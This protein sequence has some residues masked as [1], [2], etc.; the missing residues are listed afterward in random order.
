MKTPRPIFPTALSGGPPLT[1][2]TIKD[3][4]EAFEWLRKQAILDVKQ[5]QDALVE[6]DALYRE[7]VRMK[8][9]LRWIEQCETLKDARQ[10]A[11]HAGI[12]AG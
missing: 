9:A 10:T 12:C 5:A 8:A 6:W 11:Q 2:A 4:R 7:V 3:R 1:R